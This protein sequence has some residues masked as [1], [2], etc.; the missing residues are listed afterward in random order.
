MIR[1][2]TFTNT[3]RTIERSIILHFVELESLLITTST[4]RSVHLHSTSCPTPVF[5]LQN[6]W[7]IFFT[8]LVW[9]VPK[10]NQTCSILLSSV[11][12]SLTHHNKLIAD[13]IV[14]SVTRKP[15]EHL[16]AENSGLTPVLLEV[17]YCIQLDFVWNPRRPAR[18]PGKLFFGKSPAKLTKP[19]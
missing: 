16:W 11:S 2:Q 8:V 7:C 15:V 10:T 18:S 12:M 14:R 9:F 4:I 19:I 6:L 3:W 5:Y 1:P 17:F 13:A